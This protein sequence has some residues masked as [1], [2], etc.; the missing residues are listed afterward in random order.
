MSGFCQVNTMAY[1][2]D[3]IKAYNLTPEQ[4][5]TFKPKLSQVEIEAIK[6]HVGSRKPVVLRTPQV[7]F[8]QQILDE[9]KSDQINSQNKSR[10]QTS[11]ISLPI[12]SLLIL[13]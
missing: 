2:P 3:Q 8:R 12:A 4:T 7:L 10:V 13:Q 6:Q 5:G 1:T 11:T 9:Q